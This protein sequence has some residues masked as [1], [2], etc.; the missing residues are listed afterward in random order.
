MQI[1]MCAER[2]RAS[3]A[4]KPISSDSTMINVTASAG[5]AILSSLVNTERE[6]LAAADNALYRAKAEGRNRVTAATVGG[7]S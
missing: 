7:A 1:Q 5:V 3:V 6:A 4:D 2:I